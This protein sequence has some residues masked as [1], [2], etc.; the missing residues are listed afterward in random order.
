[1]CPPRNEEQEQTLHLSTSPCQEKLLGI[2]AALPILPVE[3]SRSGESNSSETFLL[4]G[5]EETICVSR[6]DLSDAATAS[7][8]PRLKACSR[9]Y[10]PRLPHRSARA[11]IHAAS[12]SDRFVARTHHFILYSVSEMLVGINQNHEFFKT[13]LA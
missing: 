4:I 5:I 9:L 11:T 10:L 6:L 13:I 7:E 2:H 12:V 3:D 1:M 8:V